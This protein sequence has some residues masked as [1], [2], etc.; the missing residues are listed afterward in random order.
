M[1]SSDLAVE[2]EIQ[3]LE[4]GR[5]TLSGEQAD[6]RLRLGTAR[7]AL[8]SILAGPPSG[9]VTVGDM[10]D[11]D[12]ERAV[13]EVRAILK[14]NFVIASTVPGVPERSMITVGPGGQLAVDNRPAGLFVSATNEVRKVALRDAKNRYC[15]EFVIDA[16][17]HEIIKS[18]NTAIPTGWRSAIDKDG[19]ITV[20]R[21]GKKDKLIEGV[22]AGD[23]AAEYIVTVAASDGKIAGAVRIDPKTGDETLLVG[24]HRASRRANLFASS[25]FKKEGRSVSVTFT[26]NPL[27]PAG[28][29][30]SVSPGIPDSWIDHIPILRNIFGARARQIQREVAGNTAL[31]ESYRQDA[32]LRGSEEL[33]QN[34]RESAIRLYRLTKERV[35]IT[36]RALRES[37]AEMERIRPYLTAMSD[38]FA[39]FRLEADMLRLEE[40]NDDAENNLA[41]TRMLLSV[42]DVDESALGAEAPSGKA[43]GIEIGRAHV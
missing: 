32:L 24:S 15:G 10:T 22:R 37:R 39:V 13:E 27:S 25:A 40:L 42:F 18:D 35:N 34:Q 38:P 19:R 3:S 30:G 36:G 21:P 29:I 4:A 31:Q 28:V 23:Q 33:A 26:V 12:I 9:A 14:G 20:T 16:S 2:A 5:A 43:V 17:T 41:D 8:R 6:A 11:Q 7:N 1:C